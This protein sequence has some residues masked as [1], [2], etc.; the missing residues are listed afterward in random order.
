MIAQVSH[1]STCLLDDPGHEDPVI[2]TAD[3]S[4]PLAVGSG[5]PG[6]PGVAGSPGVAGLTVRVGRRSRVGALVGFVSLV[7]VRWAALSVGLFG[8][9]VASRLIGLPGWLVAVVFVGCYVSGGWEPGLAGLR[10]LRAR[11]LDVDLLM[12]VAA[13]AAAA[14]GRARASHSSAARSATFSGPV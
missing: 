11:S 12:I 4:R 9:A 7:E 2:V 6:V 8:V 10:A 5:V 1:T 14:I 3:T 13:V